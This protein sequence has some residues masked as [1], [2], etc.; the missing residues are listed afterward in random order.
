MFC[1]NLQIVN[2]PKP[3][4]TCVADVAPLSNCTA[5]RQMNKQMSVCQCHS[6][7]SPFAANTSGIEGL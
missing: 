1:Y 2:L 5:Q 3:Y 4:G 6:V 7:F